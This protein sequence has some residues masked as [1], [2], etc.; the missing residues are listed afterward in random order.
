[1]WFKMKSVTRVH[2]IDSVS[3]SFIGVCV[4]GGALVFYT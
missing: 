1:M 4:G 2:L 3:V